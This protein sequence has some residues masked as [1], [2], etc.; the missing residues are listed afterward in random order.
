MFSTTN[1]E[2]VKDFEKVSSSLSEKYV[3]MKTSEYI[4]TFEPMFEFSKARQY[5]K[6]SSAHY[7]E[8]NKGEDINVYIENS[9]DGT[10]SMRIAFRFQDFIF[11]KV[12]QI[13]K[14]I[15]AVNM[16]SNK[17]DIVK[18][19]DQASRTTDSMRETDFTKEE[20]DMICEVA[21][22]VKSKKSKFVKGITYDTKN[23]LDFVVTLLSD[24]REGN[25][26]YKTAKGWRPLRETKSQ[27]TMVE[28]SNAIWGVIHKKFPEFYI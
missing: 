7:V 1:K 28:I 17:S 3:P 23:G 12:R 10:L 19:Y 2:E 11:G 27:M 18:L 25:L 8:L 4:A 22:A 5:R 16:N 20:K 13:H 21:L 6:G 15:P 24:I 9:F 26:E 14:G